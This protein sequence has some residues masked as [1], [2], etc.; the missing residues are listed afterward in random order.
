[1]IVLMFILILAI[2]FSTIALGQEISERIFVFH[3]DLFRNDKI[4]INEIS[5][6]DG[7]PTDF[8]ESNGDYKIEVSSKNKVLYSQR[9]KISFTAY[10]F[11]K[12]PV[13]LTKVNKYWRLPYYEEAEYIRLYYNN[14]LLESFYIPDYVCVEDGKCLDY[15][16]DL[17]D[18][19][20]ERK[21]TSTTQEKTTTTSQKTESEPKSKCGNDICEVSENRSSCQTDCKAKFPYYILWEIIVIII[22]VISILIIYKSK[23]VSEGFY[24]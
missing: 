13:N 23:K 17:E 15:C 8:M 10:P 1:M 6:E 11:G 16:E 19:D 18:V 24:D 14:N 5:L 4:E 2:F 12:S 20:C 21:T 22:V 3:A 9:V 7:I